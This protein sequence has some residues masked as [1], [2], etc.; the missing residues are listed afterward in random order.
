MSIGEAPGKV[1]LLGE[2]AVVHGHPALAAPVHQIRARAELLD[3]QPGPSDDLWVEAPDVALASWLRALDP[4]SAIPRALR[5]AQAALALPSLPAMTLRVTSSIPVA[6]GLGS[7]AAVTLAIV[8]ALSAHV[9]RSLP[10]DQQSAIVFE[11]DKFHHGTPSGIDNTVITYGAPIR[12]LAGQPARRL[13]PARALSLLIADSGVASS[14]SKAVAGVRLLLQ[15]SPEETLACFAAIHQI[16]DR[17]TA[18]IEQGQLDAFGACMNENQS[19]LR[20]LGVSSPPL[21]RLLAAANGAGALGAKL[22]GAGLGGNVVVLVRAAPAPDVADA[23]R[24]AGARRI[25]ETEV[26]A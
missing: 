14:T 2:H 13:H 11:V 12:F 21:E 1:I 25:L 23:L 18:A 16:V 9:G 5:L 17:G 10:L 19:Q 15:Q 4:Q 20:V 8:R 7:G 24:K 6:S 26:P 3:S 22:S